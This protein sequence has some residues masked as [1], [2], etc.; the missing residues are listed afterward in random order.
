[1]GQKPRTSQDRLESP[2]IEGQGGG[3]EIEQREM[4]FGHK[5][6]ISRVERKEPQDREEWMTKIAKI[7]LCGYKKH[8]ENNRTKARKPGK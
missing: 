4:I 2:I 8:H 6:H 5:L 1:M 7:L 3:R